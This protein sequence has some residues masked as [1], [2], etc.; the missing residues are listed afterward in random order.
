VD[1]GKRI[2]VGPDVEQVG[3]KREAFQGTKVKREAFQGTDVGKMKADTTFATVVTLR[4]PV[5]TPDGFLSILEEEPGYQT[6]RLVVQGP[7]GW[8][9]CHSQEPLSGVLFCSH[10]SLINSLVFTSFAMGK[11]GPLKHHETP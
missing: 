4:W 9:R 2:I 6:G 3:G 8:L 11:R 10:C 1:Q 7:L 5:G